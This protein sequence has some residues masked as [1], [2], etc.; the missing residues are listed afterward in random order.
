MKNSFRIGGNPVYVD[1]D[2]LEHLA[3][4][5]TPGPWK[6]KDENENKL[7]GVVS[8]WSDKVKPSNQSGWGDCRGIHICEITHQG[9]NECVSKIQAMANMN[10]IVE[11][12]PETLI[13]LIN[14]L[15][16]SKADV[17]MLSARLKESAEHVHRLE[18]E[19]NR[20]QYEINNIFNWEKNN[21]G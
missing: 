7:V 8:P 21:G 13:C 12:N 6:I 2:R 4:A 1:I 20:I 11:A 16:D 17:K 10:F 9:D 15:R 5:A 14:E 18:G 3:N 19:L